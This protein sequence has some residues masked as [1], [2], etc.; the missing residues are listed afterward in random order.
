MP[1]QRAFSHLTLADPRLAPY[2]AASLRVL[3]AL[4]LLET[5]QPALRHGRITEGSRW[6][7]PLELYS[8]LRQDAVLLASAK[9]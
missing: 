4:G 7:V 2:G 1:R 6:I 3:Q 9:G 5:L 8:P